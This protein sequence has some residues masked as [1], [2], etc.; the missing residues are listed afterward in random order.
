VATADQPVTAPSRLLLLGIFPEVFRRLPSLARPLPLP[1]VRTEV[2]FD[3]GD[4]C[5]ASATFR[6]LVSLGR[7][8]TVKTMAKRW[9]RHTEALALAVLK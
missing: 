9:I 8:L 4:D 6:E 2:D 5:S 7:R 1:G 3:A